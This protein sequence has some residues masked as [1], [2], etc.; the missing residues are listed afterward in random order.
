MN[1]RDIIKLE[2]PKENQP[3]D[4]YR[5]YLRHLDP[6]LNILEIRLGY[7]R[8]LQG[9]ALLHALESRRVKR[10]EYGKLLNQIGIS[11][12][13][14]FNCRKIAMGV[15]RVSA[16]KLGYSEMLRAVGILKDQVDEEDAASES[17]T[18][19]DE[20][21]IDG[22]E[23]PL[24]RVTFHNF[25]EKLHHARDVLAAMT[26]L[27]YAPASSEDALQR[28]GEALEQ[29][30]SIKK[31]CSNLDKQLAERIKTNKKPRRSKTRAA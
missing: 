26:E 9:T 24:P 28:Y 7:L 23:N 2:T 19:L 13:T 16:E 30:Q 11:K 31:L 12:P 20:V 27:E 1:D 10:G 17:T 14:A 29:V 6:M 18:M 15:P 4:Y 21:I 5:K 22:V 8:W 25:V 3:L